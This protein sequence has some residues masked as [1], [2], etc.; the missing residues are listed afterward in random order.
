MQARTC[1]RALSM[2]WRPLKTA[3]RWRVMQ[4]PMWAV[5]GQNKGQTRLSRHQLW[6][7]PKGPRS[8]HGFSNM[9]M[10]NQ[11]LHCIKCNQSIG[12]AAEHNTGRQ[13]KAKKIST[14]ATAPA[15]NVSAEWLTAAEADAP[16]AEVITVQKTWHV[17]KI[18]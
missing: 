11:C 12:S 2:G 4:F 3:R 8:P 13:K 5:K 15:V 14:V 1:N 9:S 17:N 18:R 7:W 16:G 6:R 10:F